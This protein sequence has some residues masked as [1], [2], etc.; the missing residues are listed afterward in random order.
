[1]DS[2]IIKLCLYQN[3]NN[4]SYIGLPSVNNKYIY[5]CENRPD[6]VLESSFYVINPAIAIRP[7]GTELICVKNDL[8]HTTDLILKYDPFN[9]ETDCISFLAWLEPTPH[10]APLYIWK[11]GN[12]R[13][14]SFS[15]KQPNSYQEEIFSP[16]YVLVNPKSNIPIVSKFTDQNFDI[17]NNEPQFKFVGYQGRCLPNPTGLSI[18]DCVVLYGKNVLSPKFQKRQPTLL[19]YIDKNYNKK[20]TINSNIINFGV[21]FIFFSFVILMFVYIKK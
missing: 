15:S 19:D 10:T 7:E 2:N 8:N 21:I 3:L 5:E 17:I 11:N 18:G 6:M 9:I 14:I 16:I 1:M 4:E 12:S 13:V 20:L